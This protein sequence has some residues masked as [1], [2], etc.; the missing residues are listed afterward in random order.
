MSATPSLG[1][2]TWS[3]LLG[4]RPRSG[5]GEAYDIAPGHDAWIIG[6]DTFVGLEFKS[7]DQYAKPK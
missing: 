1:A 2:C 7:A 5:L 4:S 3:M 6:K